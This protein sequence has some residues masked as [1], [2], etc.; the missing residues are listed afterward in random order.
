MASGEVVDTAGQVI[1]QRSFRI[2]CFVKTMIVNRGPSAAVHQS[3]IVSNSLSIRLWI[4]MR[5]GA[6]TVHLPSSDISPGIF[7][8]DGTR[9]IHFWNRGS[10]RIPL[11]FCTSSAEL[12]QNFYRQINYLHADCESLWGTEMTAWNE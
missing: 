9:P 12:I 11:V 4:T 5:A 7:S 3:F 8:P 6:G 1:K 2:R 10:V